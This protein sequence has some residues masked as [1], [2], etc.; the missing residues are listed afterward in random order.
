MKEIQKLD[1]VKGE[2]LFAQN[3][4]PS[5]QKGKSH[6]TPSPELESALEASVTQLFESA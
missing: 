5:K 3:I 4:L 6:H 2:K 1:L